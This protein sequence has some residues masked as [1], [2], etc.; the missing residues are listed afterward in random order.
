MVAI[1]VDAHKHSHTTVAVDQAGH[2]LVER[3]VAATPAIS[4]WCAGGLPSRR[5]GGPPRVARALR[6]ADR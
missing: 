3:T 4:S 5:E 1:G 2:R 6:A